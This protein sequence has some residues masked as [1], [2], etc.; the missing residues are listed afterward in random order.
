M[1]MTDKDIVLDYQQ[2]KDR[3]AQIGILADLNQCDKAKI[4]AILEKGGALDAANAL[5]ERC[6]RVMEE[7]GVTQLELAGLARIGKD[8]LNRFLCGKHRPQES[9]AQKLTAVL[10]RLEFEADVPEPKP[11]PTPVFKPKPKDQPED[12]PKP[13]PATKQPESVT[14]TRE[15]AEALLGLLTDVLPEY[16]EGK[17]A[18]MDLLEVHMLT[19]IYQKCL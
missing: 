10:D 6:A 11:K 5:R 1:T 15:E 19:G 16:I 2:A 4:L 13:E 9:T 3:N 12:Q 7:K 18:N 17:V 14:L 8:T